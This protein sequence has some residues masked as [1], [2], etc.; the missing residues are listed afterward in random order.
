MSERPHIST[1]CAHAGEEPLA[2]GSTPS[3]MPIYQ[4]S[5][6]DFPDLDEVDEIF[7]HRKPGFIYGR[8]GLPNHAAFETIA[9]KLEEAEGAIASASGMAAIAVAFWTLIQTGDEVLIANDCYGGTLGLASR[10]FSR[11][12]IATRFVPTTKLAGL[13]E[14]IS[15]RTKIL[16]V[17]TLSN[18]VWNVIDVSALAEMCHRKGIKL[19]VDNTVATPYLIRP[20]T[21]GADVVLHSATKFLAG[22]HDITAGLIIGGREFIGRAREVQIRMG[23]SLAPFDAWLAVRSIKTFPLRMAQI[24]SSALAIA[25]FLANHRKVETVYYPGLPAHPQHEIVRRTMRGLGGGMLSFDL[26]GGTGSAENFVKRLR[27]I[28]FAPSFGGV[29][30]TISHPAKTSHRS[31]TPA[32]RAE[33]GISDTLLRLSIGIEEPEDI[34]EELERVLKE[35]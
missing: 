7:D 31:L 30:T 5:V 28:R 25:Q 8:Y 35:I 9:A 17:E 34:I 22:H 29:M 18:P 26:K 33:A 27:L 13:E 16:L 4:T 10:D 2:P 15:P 12:G 11:L 14:A 6:Y 23:S 19:L 1:D 21:L 3:V 20:L 32:Q 24:C